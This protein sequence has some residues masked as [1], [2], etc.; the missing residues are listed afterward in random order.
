MA[1]KQY[2]GVTKFLHW[3]IAFFI[4]AMLVV[5]FFL[6]DIPSDWQGLAYTGHKSIGISLLFL[7][8]FRFFWV[9]RTGKPALP[10]A[11]PVWE[12]VLARSVQY[13][14]YLDVVAMVLI[15][16]IM[17]TAA[18]Y[19]PDYFGLYPWAFPGIE[20]DKALAEKLVVAH[21]YGAWVLIGLLVAHTAGALKHHLIDKDNVLKSM[22]P[23]EK[24]K[25]KAKAKKV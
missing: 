13:A 19:I 15:G 10:K 23:E 4:I 5:G 21:E 1:V 6:E 8:I 2:H 9:L 12:R 7:M 25:P 3:F 16:W 18:G 14:L 24:I 11:T 17:S 20:P 22:L